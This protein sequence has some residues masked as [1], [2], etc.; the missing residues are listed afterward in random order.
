ML[1][2]WKG[3]WKKDKRMTLLFAAGMLGIFLIFISGWGADQ[4]ETKTSGSSLPSAQSDTYAQEYASNLE[5]QLEEIL[6]GAEGIGKVQ[7]MITLESDTEYVYANTKRTD[8]D[9]TK[10]F[11][12]TN[13]EKISERASREE[14][15][16]LIDGPD[17]KQ[18]LLVTRREP[19]IQG[20]IILC[21]GGT[22]ASIKEQVTEAA[23]TALGISALQVCVLPA[24]TS[25]TMT[26]HSN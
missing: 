24:N 6:S 23:M 12:G 25:G 18:A 1:E 7:V 4:K 17:G 26:G 14:S 13:T 8:V 11:N 19:T 5:K 15:T 16:V 3:L 20:V 22:R 9:Q 21:E 2:K 10:D